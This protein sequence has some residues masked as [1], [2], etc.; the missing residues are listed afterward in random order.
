MV[1]WSAAFALGE[2]AKNHSA[3][4]KILLP[5]IKALVEKETNNGVKNVYLKALKAIERKEK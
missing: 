2:V 5:E 4:A 3:A 1:R